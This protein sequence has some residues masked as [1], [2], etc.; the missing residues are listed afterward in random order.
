MKIGDKFKPT[1]SEVDKLEEIVSLTN[2]QEAFANL[3]CLLIVRGYKKV[4]KSKKIDLNWDEEDISDFLAEQIETCC[5]EDE[6]PYHVDTDS[7]DR[8][9]SVDG[10][11]VKGK[12]RKRFD[13]KFSFFS[14]PKTENV[15]GVEAKLLI[16][17]NFPPKVSKTLMEAYIS[18]KGMRKFVE[19]IY[20]KP[21][22]MIGY[23]IEGNP[24][25]IVRKINDC[26]KSDT[27]YNSM[28]VLK[29]KETLESL[30]HHYESVHPGSPSSPLKHL[31]LD[32]TI[33]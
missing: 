6:Y 20:S 22:C 19:S 31:I 33:K 29:Q 24:S 26:I 18:V 5:R 15:F 1:S 27:F 11:V 7:R 8:D 32:M 13:I 14:D 10:I 21:G 25:E 3:C 12:K 28:T 4:I 17:N 2:A 23:V 30:E 9:G 16:E